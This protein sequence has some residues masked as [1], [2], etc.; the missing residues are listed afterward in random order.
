MNK[1]KMRYSERPLWN[2]EYCEKVVGLDKQKISKYSKWKENQV[3]EDMKEYF[4]LTNCRKNAPFSTINKIFL[5]GGFD[6]LGIKEI[7]DSKG[8]L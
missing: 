1:Y 7:T 3:N 6:Q 8:K 2:Q 4:V 5:F